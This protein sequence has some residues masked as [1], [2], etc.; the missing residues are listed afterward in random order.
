MTTNHS[1]SLWYYRSIELWNYFDKFPLCSIFPLENILLPDYQ[2]INEHIE[3]ISKSRNHSNNV[4]NPGDGQ[5][6]EKMYQ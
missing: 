1:F 3:I 4:T 5:S 6:G 2:Q